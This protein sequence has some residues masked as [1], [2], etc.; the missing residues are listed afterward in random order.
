M[1]QKKPMPEGKVYK[2]GS[3]NFNEASGQY[4]QNPI[5][6]K[7]AMNKPAISSMAVNKP[8]MNKPVAPGMA[9]NKPAMNKPPMTKRQARMQAMQERFK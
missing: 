9:V 5:M 7:P 4:S 2:G 8:A 1:E 3:Q 6:N